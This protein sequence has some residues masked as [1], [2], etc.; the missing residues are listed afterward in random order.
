ME[1]HNEN[2]NY[3]DYS[4]NLYYKKLFSHNNKNK[5]VFPIITKNLENIKDNIC[6]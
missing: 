1:N 3:E 2:N 5:N 6:S 4:P